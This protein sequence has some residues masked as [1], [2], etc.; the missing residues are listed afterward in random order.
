MQRRITIPVGFLLLTNLVVCQ[1]NEEAALTNGRVFLQQH[2]VDCHAGDQAN[3][4]WS[5][6]QLQALEAENA[7]LW[8]RVVTQVVTGNMPP[9][10]HPQPSQQD[11][12]QLTSFV[13]GRLEELG[14]DLEIDYK[15]KQPDYANLI[16][17]DKLF[18]GSVIGP[19]FSPPRLWRL[20]PEA[21]E[22]V[23][24]GFGR[25][26]NLGGTAEQTVLSR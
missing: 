20:H 11:V 21:Y 13:R 15:L 25:Q 19:A 17:H 14:I 9:A 7:E 5:L 10:E 24:E 8:Q 3:A 22:I 16:N 4:D 26:L 18:D 6:D 1:A 12:E 23:L 2:C